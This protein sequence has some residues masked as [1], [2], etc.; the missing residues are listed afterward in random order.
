MDS[1]TSVTGEVLELT[2]DYYISTGVRQVGV[3]T[4]AN[5]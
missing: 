1:A 2:A 5:T 3:Q 4:I